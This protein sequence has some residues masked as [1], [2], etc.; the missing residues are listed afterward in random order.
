MRALDQGKT[1]RARLPAATEG[2]DEEK[3]SVDF[4]VPVLPVGVRQI[5][6][7]APRP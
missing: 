6:I 3:A 2:D 5:R 1:V 7:A 4:V